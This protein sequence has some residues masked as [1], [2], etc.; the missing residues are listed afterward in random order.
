MSAVTAT[1][2]GGARAESRHVVTAVDPPR[3]PR[4]EV[5]GQPGD[6]VELGSQGVVHPVSAGSSGSGQT[7]PSVL[8]GSIRPALDVKRC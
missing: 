8:A 7:C 5:S 3:L 4:S 1:S 2:R 6:G